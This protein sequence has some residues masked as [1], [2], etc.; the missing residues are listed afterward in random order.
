MMKE[1]KNKQRLPE[2]KRI[3]LFMTQIQQKF[4]QLLKYILTNNNNNNNN[5][6][7]EMSI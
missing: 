5:N 1:K 6:N 2:K 4:V 7:N 3:Q